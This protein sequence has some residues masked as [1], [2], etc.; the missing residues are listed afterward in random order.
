MRLHIFHS[1]KIENSVEFPKGKLEGVFSY[2]YINS[3]TYFKCHFSVLPGT[4]AH[5]FT[6]GVSS[7]D[8]L[9]ALRICFLKGQHNSFHNKAF[10]F[11]AGNGKTQQNVTDLRHNRLMKLTYSSYSVFWKRVIHRQ[12]SEI[13]LKGTLETIIFMLEPAQA[14]RYGR[15]YTSFSK[16]R[17]VNVDCTTL[18]Y[19]LCLWHSSEDF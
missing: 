11:R 1:N 3:L 4:S 12:S 14:H 18:E 2:S 8:P 5:T 7:Q 9:F 16:I 10:I 13:K 6:W 15:F 19:H 17:T